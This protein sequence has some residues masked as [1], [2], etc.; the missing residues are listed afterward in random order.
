MAPSAV[1]PKS[2]LALTCPRASGRFRCEAGKGVA[3]SPRMGGSR[4]GGSSGRVAGKGVPNGEYRF[5]TEKKFDTTLKINNNMG[6]CSRDL[7][8]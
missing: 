6:R 3:R 1:K 2:L 4:K 7:N 5:L 8:R